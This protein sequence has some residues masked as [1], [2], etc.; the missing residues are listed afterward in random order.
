MEEENRV[1]T[2]KNQVEKGKDGD[3]E[4]EGEKL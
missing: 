3:K 2:G 4:E 1:M